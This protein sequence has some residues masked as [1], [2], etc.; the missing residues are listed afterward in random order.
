MKTVK[1]Y[2]MMSVLLIIY[3]AAVTL[4]IGSYYIY[5]DAYH[6]LSRLVAHSSVE[7]FYEEE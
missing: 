1:K 7:V 4:L 3:F 2:M 6:G 5:Q